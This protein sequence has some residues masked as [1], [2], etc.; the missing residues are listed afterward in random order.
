VRATV[1][2][3]SA[4]AQL[5]DGAYAPTGVTNPASTYDD[6]YVPVGFTDPTSPKSDK[7][8]R[9]MYANVVKPYCR[10]C[11]VSQT[12]YPFLSYDE[13]VGAK[14]FIQND[15]CKKYTMPQAE[16]PALQSWDS[17]ARAHLVNA[18]GLSTACA[19]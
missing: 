1:A 17:P 11:H 19:P 13:L 2:D 10:T 12:R 15:L 6:T 4:T 3:S 9:S 5:I 14:T 16:Q 18:L 7:L 8:K